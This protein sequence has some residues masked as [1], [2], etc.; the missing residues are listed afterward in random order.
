MSRMIY[1]DVIGVRRKFTAG[2]APLI[3]SRS[4]RIPI[5]RIG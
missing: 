4:L 2:K 1:S 3:S 5:L